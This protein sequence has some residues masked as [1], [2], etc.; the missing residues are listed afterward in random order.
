MTL[1]DSDRG[2]PMGRAGSDAGSFTADCTTTVPARDAVLLT[3]S[4]TAAS[5]STYEDTSTA[6]TPAF[7]GSPRPSRWAV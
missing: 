3:V 5:G 6:T 4:G 1:T 7:S 2:L